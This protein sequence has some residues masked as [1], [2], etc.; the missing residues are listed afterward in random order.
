MIT[1]T[2]HNNIFPTL[3]FWLGW[4]EETGEEFN[5]NFAWNFNWM[6]HIIQ[7]V[8]MQKDGASLLS[9]HLN[10]H[11]NTDASNICIFGDKTIYVLVKVPP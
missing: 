7:D 11:I 10:S 2:I 3:H 4:N 1:Q 9:S 8:V 6:I 5:F